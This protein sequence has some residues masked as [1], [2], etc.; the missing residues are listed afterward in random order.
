[1]LLVITRLQKHLWM[2]LF[3]EVVQQFFAC[4]GPT[5]RSDY[6][7][8]GCPRARLKTCR[9]FLQQTSVEDIVQDLHRVFVSLTARRHG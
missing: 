5:H 9:R 2:D 7:I 4:T 6:C 3:P 1:M 8:R